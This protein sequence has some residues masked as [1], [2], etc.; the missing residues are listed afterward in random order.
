MITP[1]FEKFAESS[2]QGNI[3]PVYK[4]VTA[5]LLKPVLDDLKVDDAMMMFFSTILAFDHARQQILI[6]SNAFIEESTPQLEV[7]YQK[8]V[9]E[10]EALEALLNQPA[11]IP[12]FGKAAEASERI[13]SNFS[14]ADY[15]AAV[16]KAKEH[17]KA[18]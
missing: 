8:A 4:A 10:I 5:D 1:T 6:I 13:Q 7:K 3:I 15:L 18:G 2:K 17:I 16:D 14:K 12:A 11:A 9:A